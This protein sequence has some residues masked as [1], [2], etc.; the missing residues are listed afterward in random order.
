MQNSVSAGNHYR[1]ASCVCLNT[2]FGYGILNL[3]HCCVCSL[4]LKIGSL[5]LTDV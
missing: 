5:V 2:D 3:A 1:L 4:A